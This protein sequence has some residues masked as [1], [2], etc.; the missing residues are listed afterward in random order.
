MDLAQVAT[1]LEERS[2]DHIWQ[3]DVIKHLRR[4]FQSF[5]TGKP[6]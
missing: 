5:G 3:I 1:I 6:P 4:L 2:E